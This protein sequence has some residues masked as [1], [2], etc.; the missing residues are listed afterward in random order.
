VA[1]SCKF[2][3]HRPGRRNSLTARH[4]QATPLSELAA[5]HGEAVKGAV[6][7]LVAISHWATFGTTD[8][9]TLRRK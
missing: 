9:L 5:H 4:R 3:C 7:W 2:I 8:H 1:N 6:V